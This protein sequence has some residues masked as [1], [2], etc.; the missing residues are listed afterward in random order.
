M[1]IEFITSHKWSSD[2][3]FITLLYER[4]PRRY[5]LFFCEVSTQLIKQ[6]FNKL[7][8]INLFA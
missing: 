4:V 8:I 6:T 3:V 2:K 5:L 7:R 1:K